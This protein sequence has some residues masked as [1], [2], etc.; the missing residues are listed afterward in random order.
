FL[1]AIPIIAI[2][3]FSYDRYLREVKTSA[4]QVELAER[5]RAEIE[6]ERAEQAE[7]H[8]K[9]LNNYIAEQERISRALEETKEHFRHA[10]FHDSLTGLP[11]RAMFAE[12]LKAEIENARHAR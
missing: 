5:D 10:A 9:E 8:V 12:L 3:Y 2:V 4:Q 1:V 7:R 6:R 11:N